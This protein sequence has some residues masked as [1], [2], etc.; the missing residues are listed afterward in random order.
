[1]SKSQVQVCL[2]RLWTQI[3]HGWIPI[4]RSK[5]STGCRSGHQ[6]RLYGLQEG[7]GSWIP[8]KQKNECLKIKDS[9]HIVSER[10]KS[11]EMAASSLHAALARSINVSKYSVEKRWVLRGSLWAPNRKQEMR[12]RFMHVER[13]RCKTQTCKPLRRSQK[14]W[15]VPLMIHHIFAPEKGNA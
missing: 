14:L 15:V 1:M 9:N 7:S 4:Q 8:K 13:Y 3:R 11:T 2:A 12:C 5:S 6:G 10:I